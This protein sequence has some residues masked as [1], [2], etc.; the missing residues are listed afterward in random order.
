LAERFFAHFD[1]SNETDLVGEFTAQAS[2]S[3][4]AQAGPLVFEAADAGSQ[5]AQ[6]VIARAG[7]QLARQIELARARGAVGEVVV[8]AGGVLVN[9]QGLVDAIERELH[10]AGLQLDSHILRVPPVAG[11]LERA[12]RISV[13]GHVPAQQ[14]EQS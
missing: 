7:A 8:F 2:I 3:R 9:R 5:R 12:R 14:K 10:L 13:G 1:V 6:D 4:W 11:A